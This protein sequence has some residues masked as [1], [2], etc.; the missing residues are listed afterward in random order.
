MKYR[1]EVD[2]LRAVAVVPVILFHAGVTSFYGGFL[3]VDIFFVISGYLITS[4]IAEEIHQGGFSIV[5][6]YERRARRILPALFLIVLFAILVAPFALNP[7]QMKDF[8]ESLVGISTF[9]SNIIFWLQSGYFGTASEKSPLL[10]TWSLAVEEQF[11][12]FFPLLLMFLWAFAKKLVELALVSILLISL[13]LAHWASAHT[14]DA[15]FYLLPT[16]TWE[17]MIGSLVG[18]LLRNELF[19]NTIK[20]FQNLLSLLSFT[21]LLASF[22]F[23]DSN[24]P[25]PSL[26][27]LIP[28]G[29]T[30]VLIA[31][32]TT[33]SIVG[34]I[35]SNRLMVGVGLISYSLYLWHQPLFAFARLLMPEDE[36]KTIILGLSVLSVLMA[37]FS[38]RFVEQPF[39][40]KRSFGRRKIFSL[41]LVGLVVIS[42]FGGVFFVYSKPI[43]EF[44]YPD[45][46][47]NYSIIEKSTFG[48]AGDIA[49]KGCYVWSDTF[50]KKFESRF[51]ACF[52][53]YGKAV[54][55]TGDSHGIDLYNSVAAVTKRPFVAS[56]TRGA[57]R[58]HTTLTVRPP[59]KC[60]Y[61][62]LKEFS[63]ENSDKISAVV[64]T[65]TPD[66]F[67]SKPFEQ[68]N[69]DDVSR[70]ALNEVVDYLG[71][72]KKESGVRVVLF[73]MLPPLKRNPQEFD[74]K[75]DIA[76][77]AKQAVSAHNI[78]LAQEVD[79]ELEKLAMN[80]GITFISK[81][82][83]FDLDL[84]R[85]LFLDEKLM[86]SDA[87]HISRY[88]EKLFGGR[89]LDY[90]KEIG[91]LKD[92]W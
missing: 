51:N 36:Q 7:L 40:N 21:V 84:E 47:Y 1:P 58:A 73:G 65:Q 89:L 63:K 56:I 37:Y 13:I 59:Y 30:A 24:T 90:L 71:D 66:R 62:Q 10:H 26:W 19:N 22:A 20:P 48:E 49:N 67:F 27:T 34:K 5:N 79:S 87:R 23:F 39:R 42:V 57:C 55:I 15:N 38:W 69:F 4:L 70:V 41:S 85:D 12:V 91:E 43:F 53:K 60:H 45:R 82:D 14:A 72:L 81:V 28:V 75:I 78:R 9:S 17:L 76:T 3:G 54:L 52:K 31:S 61:D 92:L 32:T 46:F 11:Y 8:G 25:H 64:Y 74:L 29:A 83:S 18:L 88:G 44:V 35:L 86:Y 77:Q 68:V 80:K 6:F 16:R 33:E 2:G 50:T